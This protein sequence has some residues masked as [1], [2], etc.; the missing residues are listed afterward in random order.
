MPTTIQEVLSDNSNLDSSN[1]A[2]FTSILITSPK[3]LS[4]ESVLA[5]SFEVRVSLLR[6]V[7]A[8]PWRL[9]ERTLA[10]G[11]FLLHEVVVPDHGGI[12]SLLDGHVAEGKSIDIFEV[13]GNVV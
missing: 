4:M 8:A 9:R 2:I 5:P 7:S 10:S 11:A 6:L 12:A 1:L 3:A 13:L